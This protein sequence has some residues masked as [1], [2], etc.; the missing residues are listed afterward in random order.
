MNTDNTGIEA[1]PGSL[2]AE[3][4]SQLRPHL[5]IKTLNALRLSA[6]IRAIRPNVLRIMVATIGQVR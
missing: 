6:P 2:C 5:A 1:R 3:T 4:A